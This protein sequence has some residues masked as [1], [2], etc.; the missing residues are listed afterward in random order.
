MSNV[1]SWV[2]KNRPNNL[3]EICYQDDICKSL[4]KIKNN[5]PHLLF[6]GPPGSGKT[7]TI[8]ALAKVIFG[9]YYKERIYEL[10]ASD[11]RG[12]NVVREKI[13]NYAIKSINN[14]H[15]IPPWKIIILDEA[16]NMTIESQ[17]ALR[18][19]M[20]EYSKVT[21]FCI[22]CNYHHNIIDPIISRC[23]MFNF[24]PIPI[25]FIKRKLTTISQNENMIINKKIITKISTYSRGDL[26]KAI[27]FLQRCYN[28]FGESINEDIIDEMSGHIPI[29][30]L[31]EFITT[32]FN[33]DEKKVNDMIN[34]IYISGYSLINQILNIHNIIVNYPI[35]DN[36]KTKIIFELINIDQN[37]I[38]GCD[39]MIQLYKLSYFIMQS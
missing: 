33:K 16:D 8:Y 1:T 14:Y 24:K 17:Y 25:K 3:D 38:E 32:C 35:E 23:S 2:E 39:E 21:R 30:Y 29:D 28:G 9:K 10:N 15:D 36:I 34:H 37:L 18:N 22:I 12:I 7:S 13:K 31:T 5:I 27:N 20:E 6:H 4:K 19:I 26:R 11:E